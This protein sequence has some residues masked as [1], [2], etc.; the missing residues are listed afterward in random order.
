MIATIAGAGGLIGSSL[1]KELRKNG[2]TIRTI[3]RGDFA[4]DDMSF[5]KEKTDG[6]DI[7]INLAGASIATRWTEVRKKEIY[8]S[9]ILTTRKITHAIGQSE[10]KPALFISASAIGIYDNIHTHDEDSASLGVGFIGNLCREWEAEA[11]NVPDTVRVVLMRTGVV[12]SDEG[13]ALEKMYLPFSLGLGGIIGDGSQPFSFI[14]MEDLLQA[15]LF[16]IRQESM[17]GPVNFV[18]PYPSTNEEFSRIFGRVLKQPVFLKIPPFLLRMKMGEGATVLMEGQKVIPKRLTD[19][20]FRWK[21]PT[22]QNA[23]V[24]LYH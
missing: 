8:D 9:R 4:L 21:Y 16:T 11:L 22:I 3:H 14:H 1:I 23:L 2:W 10:K 24:N 7:I 5:M 20:G 13:G 6:S 12:L 15:L 19:Q 17:T 18:S